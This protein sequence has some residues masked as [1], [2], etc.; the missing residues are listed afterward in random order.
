LL[1]PR[2]AQVHP[3]FGTPSVITVTTVLFVA[4]LA[5]FVPLSKLAEM[6]SIGTLFAFAVVSAAVPILRRTRPDLPRP[7]RT[8]WSPLLPVLSA[9]LCVALMTNLAIETWLRFLAWLAV[10]FVLYFG[11]GV[12]RSRVGRRE[13]EQDLTAT[14]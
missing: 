10:G 7:F 3:R 1:P 8:P 11:Y 2:L 4:V 6:V 14:G 13:R 5:A 9:L 12:R